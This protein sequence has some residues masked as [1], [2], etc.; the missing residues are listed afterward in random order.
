MDVHFLNILL[1][2]FAF[3]LI[4][5]AFQTM[6]M[7]EQTL[8]QSIKKDDPNFHGSGYYS[9]AIIYAT[10]ALANWI[11][12][13]SIAVIGAKWS[14]FTG[15]ITYLHFLLSF[16]V[17]STIWLYA[18]SAVNGVGGA[19]LWT[20]QG[21]YLT[22]M[23]TGATMARNSAIFWAQFQCSLLFGNLFVYFQFGS[24]THVAAGVRRT[25]SIVLSTIC[26]AGLA[27]FLLLRPTR[28]QSDNDGGAVCDKNDASVTGADD[29]RAATS[30][31]TAENS[32]S[33]PG[34]VS[35]AKS[36]LTDSFRLMK[37]RQILLLVVTCFY[38]GAELC[39][40]SGVFGTC[41]GNT[42]SL[43]NNKRLVGMSGFL[44][45][46]G[47]ISAS[48]VLSLLSRV[49]YRRTP[50][51]IIVAGLLLH[52]TAFILCFLILPADTTWGPS[53][54]GSYLAPG[55]VT[56]LIAAWLL[57]SG[58]ACFNTQVY[59]LLGRAFRQHSASAFA[60]YKFVQSLSAALCFVLS[61]LITLHA[62]LLVLV[63]CAA[64]GAI[65]FC[66]AELMF[67]EVAAVS[68]A[69]VSPPSTRTLSSIDDSSQVSIINDVS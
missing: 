2:G 7:I 60:I 61:P 38:T 62:L 45:G 39:Y 50:V 33:T 51:F 3:T 47:E 10:F 49:S 19:L 59:S 20:G 68:S 66:F 54:S 55:S 11:A 35:A 9:L 56:V 46:V 43:P 69:P 13:S 53:S 58:D 29:G 30:G 4:F 64:F 24:T 52:L 22:Q 8:I 25:V 44:I 65:C 57:G 1:V 12:P 32:V 15:A 40:F 14:M 6:S 31:D 16:L 26:L 34:L 21:A 18:A 27:T 5:T 28:P 48:V 17:P 41:V 23:S 36:A 67:C 63:V 42:Q 37:N